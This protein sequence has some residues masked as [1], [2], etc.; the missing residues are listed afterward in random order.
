MGNL[1]TC[2]QVERGS[3]ESPPQFC[4]FSSV[5]RSKYSYA[6][7]VYCGTACVNPFAPQLPATFKGL[8]SFTS[9]LRSPSLS[10]RYLPSIWAIASAWAAAWPLLFVG[11]PTDILQSSCP[12][13]RPASPG[14]IRAGRR[15]LG[16][17][18]EGS[19]F[20]TLLGSVTR[21]IGSL[22]PALPLLRVPC[23]SCARQDVSFDIRTSLS[24]YNFFPSNLKSTTPSTRLLRRLCY[25][26][27]IQLLFICLFESTEHGLT[28]SF[29][30]QFSP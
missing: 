4:C 18:F 10:T 11:R 23:R 25:L 16:W 2:S 7:A 24:S 5:F 8:P 3:S 22:P 17:D 20:K 21:A 29:L 27:Y 26:Y 9:S 6:K 14:H 28:F 13:R 15:M 30:C 19:G 12:P 1:R